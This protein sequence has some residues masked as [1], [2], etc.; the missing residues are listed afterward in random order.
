M[1]GCVRRALV[2]GAGLVAASWGAP[3]DAYAQA[4]NYPAF[5]QSHIVNREF[6]FGVA[7]GGSGGTD[8]LFQWREGV[9]P[10]TQLSLDAGVAAAHHGGT[11]VAFFGGQY[12]YQLAEVTPSMPVELL[13]T[14]SF[15]LAF[16]GGIT[17]FRIPVGVS[18]GR[19]LGIGAGVA[20]TP[21]VMPRLALDFCNRCGRDGRG[22][23]ELGVG[24][25]L[26]VN[27]DV[28]PQVAV[29][30]A[31]GFGGTSVISRDDSFGLSL[32][33]SPPGLTKH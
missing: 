33:W 32:A 8:F 15:N 16:G 25:D 10:F 5:Q 12:A 6:N 17:F 19:K 3:I 27:L 20:L 29:R 2:G 9:F 23:S 7:D 31:A 21:F 18:V 26:G 28:S 22:R 14:G 24:T 1:I 13:G 11:T 30:F 4:W